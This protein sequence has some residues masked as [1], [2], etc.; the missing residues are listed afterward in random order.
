M[1]AYSF[2]KQFAGQIQ[3]GLKAHTI[4]GDRARHA[5]PGERVQLYSG[6]RTK[7]CV[8]L[9]PDPICLSV[10]PVEILITLFDG[11]PNLGRVKID[12]ET[13]L[14]Y[15]MEA[16]AKSDGFDPEYFRH[17]VKGRLIETA[18]ASMAQFWYDG[19]GLGVFHGFLIAWQPPKQADEPSA[20]FGRASAA[21]PQSGDSAR[22]K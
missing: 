12:G 11:E 2:K 17:V 13:L 4:R 10:Q 9:I 14:A 22:T 16:L 20:T 6:M 8:K 7:Y 3:L 5:K 18:S 21:K 19:H 1:V 15:D